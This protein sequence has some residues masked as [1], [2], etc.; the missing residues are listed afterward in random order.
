MRRGARGRFGASILNGMI[1]IDVDVPLPLALK[2]DADQI[3]R[4]AGNRLARSIR[5]RM[6]KGLDGDGSPLPMPE[7]GTPGKDSGRLLKDIRYDKK[8]GTVKPES[9]R[10]RGDKEKGKTHRVRTS[11]AV[12][13]VHIASGRWADPMGTEDPK[14]QAKLQKDIEMELQKQ[15]NKGALV[16]GRKTR[17]G[18]KARRGGRRGR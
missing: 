16:G 1:E 5:A 4:Y 13:M 6:R 11:Y 9:R 10:G 15:L 8:T 12:M 3:A 2:L 7:D 14:Q 18:R 17:G